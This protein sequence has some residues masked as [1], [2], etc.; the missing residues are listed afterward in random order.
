MTYR[1]LN[2]G[3]LRVARKVRKKMSK[4]CEK[5]MEYNPNHSVRDR[6]YLRLYGN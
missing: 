6:E 4:T 1:N 2:M 3:F 5:V